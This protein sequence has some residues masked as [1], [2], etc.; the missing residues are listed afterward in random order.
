VDGQSAGKAREVLKV[1]AIPPEIGYYFA[2]FADGEGSFNVSFRPRSD[3]AFPWKVSLCFN[4]SQRD[5]VILSLYKKHLECGTMRQRQDGVW[6]YEVNNLKP[7]LENVIPFFERFPFLSAKKRRD[8]AKFR[9]LAELLKRGRHLTREGINEIL[10]IRRGM[11]DRD[12]R[13]YTDEMILAR[14]ENPQR[15]YARPSDG[16]RQ[17]ELHGDVQSA[18]EMTAPA[19]KEARN[20]DERS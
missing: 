8:F 11:N 19:S 20:R 10:A 14:L 2:G 3:Y 9:L 15:L 5:A 4:I 16:M 18:A 1:E 12:K 13:K 7:I 6:Y 17:S